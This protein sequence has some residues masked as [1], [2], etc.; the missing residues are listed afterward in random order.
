M[1]R[2]SREKLNI[3]KSYYH[4][5]MFSMIIGILIYLT[6]ISNQLTNHYDGL[7]SDPWYGSGK[8][9][10]SIGRWFWLFLDKFRMGYSADPFNSYLSLFLFSLGNMLLADIFTLIGKKRAYLVSALILSSTTVSVFLSYR[11]MS[12][13][14]ALSY[15]LCIGSVWVLYMEKHVVISLV[16]SSGMI[17]LSLGLYQANLGCACLLVIA[18]LLFMCIEETD[19]KEI[20]KFV[21]TCGISMVVACLVYKVL[22]DISMGIYHVEPNTY[23]GASNVS[24]PLILGKMPI[25]I[26][27]AYLQF[28]KYFF[29]NSIKHNIFQPFKCFYPVFLVMLAALLWKGNLLLKQRKWLPLTVYMLGILVIPVACNVS[30]ILAPESGFLIQQTAAMAIL[31]PVLLCLVFRLYDR[32]DNFYQSGNGETANERDLKW[33][34]GVPEK[35]KLLCGIW[36]LRKYGLVICGTV[37]LSLF[38]L[39]GNLY[40]T[41]TDLEAMYEGTVSSDT[42]MNHVV[43]TLI[44]EDLCREDR[45]YIFVGRISDNRMFRKTLLW[46]KANSYA[47]YGEL[48]TGAGLMQMAYNGLLRRGGVKLTLAEEDIYEYYM[49]LDQIKDMPGYPEDG[50]IQEIE[51]RIVVKISDVY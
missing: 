11:Y 10:I 5:L 44:D 32:K 12:P 31:F 18:I 14:F 13:T 39:Y 41:A 17:C 4:F 51:G 48:W 40:M 29:E 15:L 37:C 19:H 16:V 34:F 47:R 8:W 45:E 9:E 22:W 6:L 3:R 49:K 26:K 24:I 25:R 23:N 20:L 28:Y 43:Q 21:L 38:I 36:D 46:D 2:Y 50:S 30:M 35:N 7:W 33:K 1:N 27:D 42:I